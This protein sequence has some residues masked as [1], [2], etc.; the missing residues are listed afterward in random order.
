VKV[1]GMAT[2]SLGPA[3]WA[4]ALLVLLVIFEGTSLCE[5]SLWQTLERRRSS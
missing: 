5:W 3:F 1:A 2:V 4:L